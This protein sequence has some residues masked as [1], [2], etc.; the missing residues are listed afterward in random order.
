MKKTIKRFLIRLIGNFILWL[1]H[2]KDIQNY[3]VNKITK[4]WCK[5]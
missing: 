5:L 4:G 2:F 3:V 1:L